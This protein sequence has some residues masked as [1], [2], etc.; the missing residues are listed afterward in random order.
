MSVDT[1]AP[2]AEAIP[3]GEPDEALPPLPPHWRSLARAFVHSARVHWSRPAVADSTKASATYGMAL[4]R[5]IALG[6]VLARTLGPEPYVGVMVPPSVPAVVTNLALILIGKIPINLNYTASQTVVDSAV[7]QC[8]IRHTITSHKVIEKTQLAPGGELIYLEDIPGR[9][10]KLDKIWAAATAKLAP[11]GMMGSFLPGLKAD[12]LDATATVMFTSGSTGDPKGVVLSH[13]NVLSNVHQVNTHL[14][15]L[16]DEVVLGVLPMFHSFGF[17]VT[18]WTVLLLGKKVVYHVNPLDAKIVCDLVEKHGVTMLVGTPTFMRHYAQRAKPGQLSTLYHLLLGAEKLKPELFQEIVEKTG[19][20]PLEGYGTTE[21][22]PVVS[23]NA[24]FPMTLPDGRVVD[25]NR[26]G[27]VGRLIPGT[28]VK[29]VGIEDGQDLPR[30]QEG[31]ILV[32]GPQVMVGYLDRPEATAKVLRDGWY[33]TGDIGFQDADGF[34]HITDR[35][36]RFSK[37][38]GEMVPHQGIESALMKAVGVDE[39]AVAVTSIPDAKRGE[40]LVV[41]HTPWPIS[42]AEACK[43]LVEAQL[44]RLWIPAVEDFVPIEAIPILGTGKIDLRRLREIAA[45]AA[46]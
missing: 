43:R 45:E 22:S 39:T 26:R 44:P 1:A 38:A 23:V 27:T 13:R 30:G 19:V 6:R 31:M 15:L 25:G 18:I 35:L 32:K 37:I 46:R 36:S 28:A 11:I 2:H 21:L 14:R 3:A 33:T 8:G 34:L 4:T 24:P 42:P 5:A 9:V 20:T 16:P 10:T 40:R 41:L 17:T 29:T 12:S 7:K